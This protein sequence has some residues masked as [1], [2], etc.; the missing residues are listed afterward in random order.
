MLFCAPQL[1][2]PFQQCTKLIRREVGGTVEGFPLR[3]EEAG[4]R[5]AAAAVDQHHGGHVGLIDIGQ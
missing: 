2:D 3:G 4:H 5:P 1:I